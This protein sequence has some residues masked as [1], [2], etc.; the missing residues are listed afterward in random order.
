MHSPVLIWFAVFL[1]PLS[2]EAVY[3]AKARV[4]R[5]TLQLDMKMKLLNKPAV[6]SIKMKPSFTI[7][8]ETASKKENTSY[9]QVVFQTWQRSGSCP[10][11]TVPVRRILREDLLRATSPEQFGKKSPQ[12]YLHQTNTSQENDRPVFINNTELALAQQ[13]NH[14]TALLVTVGFNYIGAQGDIN[15]WNPRVASPD[16]YTTA[17]I[18]LKSGILDSFE[19]IEAGWMVNSKLYG[20][21]QTRLLD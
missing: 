19:S 20:D 6:K 8:S 10:Q 16:K 14:S 4:T 5:E 13:V 11:G 2:D 17:Q 18:W 7:S 12:T 3:H 9:E 21:A 15:L 1:F